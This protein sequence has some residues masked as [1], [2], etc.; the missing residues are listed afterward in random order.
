LHV[1]AALE[2]GV[3]FLYSF[4]QQQRKLAQAVRLKLNRAPRLM[5]LSSKQE[6]FCWL[7]G[8]I[9]SVGLFSYSNAFKLTAATYYH[10]SALLSVVVVFLFWLRFRKRPLSD[11]RWLRI[12]AN[13]VLVIVSATFLLYVLGLQRGTSEL[14]TSGVRILLNNP[15]FFRAASARPPTPSASATA[16]PRSSHPAQ[17]LAQLRARLSNANWRRASGSVHKD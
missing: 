3:D 17:A 12:L 15:I 16:Q 9:A 10:G 8:G 7:I 1:A 13:F 2:L 11:P 4:D 6:L 5:T 14:C